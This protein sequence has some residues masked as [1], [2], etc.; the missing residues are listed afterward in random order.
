MAVAEL[1]TAQREGLPIIVVVF[2]DAEIG[3]IRIKQ[4]IKNIPLNGVKLGGVDWENWLR[5]S[6]PTP[7]SWK[8]KRRLATRWWPRSLPDARR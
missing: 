4:E 5:H 8:R 3:L 6:P 7:P 2:D 1:Q